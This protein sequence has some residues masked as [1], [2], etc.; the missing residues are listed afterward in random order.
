MRLLPSIAL[1]HRWVGLVVGLILLVLGLTGALLVFRAELTALKHPVQAGRV[2]VV[3]DAERARQLADITA[4]YEVRSVKFPRDGLDVW[5]LYLRDGTRARLDGRDLTELDRWG[6]FDDPL[7]FAFDLHAHLLMGHRGELAAGFAGLV[8]LG[9]LGT[10]I[11]L[12]WPRRRSFR[13]ALIIPR[14]TRRGPLLAAHWTTGILSVPILLIPLV[15]GIMMVF[16]ETSRAVLS[17]LSFDRPHPAPP[18][19][20]GVGQGPVDWAAALAT[21]R[22]TFPDGDLVFAIPPANPGQPAAFRVR[23][24][25]EWHPNGRSTVQVDPV[26]GALIRA[27]DANKL[28]RGERLYNTAYPLHAASVGGLAFALVTCLSGVALAWLSGAGIWAWVRKPADPRRSHGAER[29]AT[30]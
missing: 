18:P 16:P 9:M 13:A 15:T 24:P 23:L 30:W 11:A 8:A 19:T 28:S 22:A 4:R 27:V 7:E 2:S 25:G 29:N 5:E 17:A 3:E 20:D 12:W 14:A 10:G 1:L 6:R 21:V 26:T